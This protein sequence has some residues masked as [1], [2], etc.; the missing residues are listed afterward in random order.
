MI[1]FIRTHDAYVPMRYRQIYTE[2]GKTR[3]LQK[4]NIAQK[5]KKRIQSTLAMN[6]LIITSSRK[7]SGALSRMSFMVL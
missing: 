4:N 6:S 1:G 3:F 2:S 5:R 7:S